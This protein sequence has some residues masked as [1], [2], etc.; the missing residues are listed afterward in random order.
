MKT[1]RLHEAEE[2]LVEATRLEPTNPVHFVNLG[3]LYRSARLFKKARE[4]FERAIRISP[5]DEQAREE[6]RDLPEEPQP[7][8]RAEGG[9]IF[10]RLFGKG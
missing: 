5:H 8:R 10:E 9:G 4:A 3:R 1:K 2:H 6:F 7:A